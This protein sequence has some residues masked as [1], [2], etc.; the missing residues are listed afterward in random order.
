M[1]TL[2]VKAGQPAFVHD[3]GLKIVRNTLFACDWTDKA[4]GVVQNGGKLGLENCG[5]SGGHGPL[6]LGGDFSWLGGFTAGET[7]KYPAGYYGDL[8]RGARAGNILLK[9]LRFTHRCVGEA[10]GRVMGATKIRLED[11]EHDNSGHPNKEV[12]QFRHVDEVQIFDCDLMDSLVFG[13][14]PA[15][16]CKTD[17]ERRIYHGDAKAR[18]IRAYIDG[19]TRIWGHVRATGQTDLAADWTQMMAK[20]RRKAKN[21]KSISSDSAFQLTTIGGISKPTLTL[22]SIRNVGGWPRLRS[23]GGG[24]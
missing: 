4:V 16:D 21:G 11:C 3:R 19:K 20:D 14:L 12:W 15:K 22:N 10:H 17:K 7:K 1:T 13:V 8:L 2:R 5:I 24:E 9:G 6:I 18:R 23:D